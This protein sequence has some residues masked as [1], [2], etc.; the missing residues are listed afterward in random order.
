ML[1]QGPISNR[2]LL[3]YTR[4]TWTW[5]N[6]TKTRIMVH[7]NHPCAHLNAL[8]PRRLHRDTGRGVGSHTTVINACCAAG[9]TLGGATITQRDPSEHRQELDTGTLRARDELV[10]WPRR[11]GA[12]LP[13]AAAMK[14]RKQ[15]TQRHLAGTGLR[16]LPHQAAARQQCTESRG[17]RGSSCMLI[18]G[19]QAGQHR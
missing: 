15:M 9:I 3:Q 5:T 7:N 17:A 18:S 19:C 11:M 1:M 6:G 10:R 13:Q 14:A 2:C 16:T 8:R 4:A 12:R